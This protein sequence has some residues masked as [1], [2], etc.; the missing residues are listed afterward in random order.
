MTVGDEIWYSFTWPTS[1][2]GEPDMEDL[3]ERTVH[4][5]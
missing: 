2:G 3:R 5:S 4:R 1:F